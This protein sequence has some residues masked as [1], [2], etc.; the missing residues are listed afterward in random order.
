MQLFASILLVLFGIY[1]L[2]SAFLYL[3]QRRLIYYPTAADPHFGAEEITID[4]DGLRLHGWIL[5]PGK[6]RAVIYFGGNSEPI[7]Q[8]GGLFKTLFEDHSV[9]L[10]DYR[11]YGKS[12]GKPSEAGLF[13]DALAIFD[14]LCQRHQSIAAYGRSLGSGV[15]VYLA[16][17]RPLERLILLTPYDSIMAL[18]R[19]LYPLFPV[20]LLLRDRFDSTARAGDIEIPVLMVTAEHDRVIP[21]PHSLALRQRLE[22]AQLSYTMIDGAAHDDIVEFTQFHVA[23]N[24]FVA[25]WQSRPGDSSDDF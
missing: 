5:Y 20:R 17:N 19:K 24:R 7:T 18:A 9:Y 13:A 2:I 12:E 23:V 4:N 11:G 21:L 6:R 3:Y 22:R 14:F 8:N 10:I 15:A 25:D 1:L 16:A